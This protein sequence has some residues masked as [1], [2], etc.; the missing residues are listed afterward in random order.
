MAFQIVK[1]GRRNG[2]ACIWIVYFLMLKM[3]CLMWK[4]LYCFK[5]PTLREQSR[6]PQSLAEGFSSASS[7]PSAVEIS[8]PERPCSSS[9]EE[10][11]AIFHPHRFGGEDRAAISISNGPDSDSVE[12]SVSI[13]VTEAP[14]RDSTE[15]SIAVSIAEGLDTDSSEDSVVISFSDGPYGDSA[16]VSLRLSIPRNPAAT[17]R[18]EETARRRRRTEQRGLG[19]GLQGA[20]LAAPPWSF[21]C[22]E[23][24]RLARVSL[25]L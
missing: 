20:G 23:H 24:V 9:V 5:G 21:P 15:G 13:A 22:G 3:P 11:T 17:A 18:T 12:D 14:G 6:L 2:G 4:P 1:R 7:A 10:S 8:I 16:Q 25:F 19:L